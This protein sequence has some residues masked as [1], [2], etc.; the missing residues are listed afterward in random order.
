MNCLLPRFFYHISNILDRVW[1]LHNYT[2]CL[3]RR[4]TTRRTSTTTTM[5]NGMHCICILM[6]CWPFWYPTWHTY[7]WILPTWTCRWQPLS[8]SWTWRPYVFCSCKILLITLIPFLAYSSQLQFYH[9]TELWPSRTCPWPLGSIS[10]ARAPKSA[11]KTS[12]E[13]NLCL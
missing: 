7:S 12:N 13:R 6:T 3:A 4:T 11:L 8:T 1:V 5:K 9:W 2:G 10:W